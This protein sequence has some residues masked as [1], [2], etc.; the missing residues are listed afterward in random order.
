MDDAALLGTEMIGYAR[1]ET[2]RSTAERGLIGPCVWLE[3]PLSIGISVFCFFVF[4]EAEKATSPGG[5]SFS[6]AEHMSQVPVFKFLLVL[7]D[8][9]AFP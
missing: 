7:R 9:P 8:N 2:V 3:L 1:S 4:S 6:N 5:L